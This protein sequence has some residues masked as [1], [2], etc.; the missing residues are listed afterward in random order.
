MTIFQAKK[1]SII[2]YFEN[3]NINFKKQNNQDFWYLSPFHLEKTPSFKV[4]A[5]KNLWYDHGIGEGGNILDLVMKINRCDVPGALRILEGLDSSSFSFSPVAKSVAPDLEEKFK[6]VS[7][8]DLQN[9]LLLNYLEKR[10]IN[11]EIAKKF[12]VEI[13]FKKEENTKNLF[14]LGFKNDKGG[15]ETRNALFKGNIGGKSI[16][17]IKGVGNGKVAVFE[18]FMDFLSVLTK[19][20]TTTITDD[21]IVLNS[22]SMVDGV[23]PA[24]KVY[25]EVKLFLDNDKA[26]L[27][28]KDGLVANLGAVNYSHL[29]RDFKDANEWLCNIPICE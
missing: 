7:I 24:L 28:A 14:A 22:L 29:Y 17:T 21:V 1:I 5:N 19:Y 9:P 10:K 15:Y 8:K 20:N 11:I 4:D 23:I 25:K 27:N 13:Y 3:L 26:G 6:I 12:L 2:S 16:T 18:W